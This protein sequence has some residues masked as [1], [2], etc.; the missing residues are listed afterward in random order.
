MISENDAKKFCLGARWAHYED[1]RPRD[2]E[3][4]GHDRCPYAMR[5]LIASSPEAISKA[6]C[7][8]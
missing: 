5:H 8:G 4:C 7:R 3:E 1:P 6:D 2:P